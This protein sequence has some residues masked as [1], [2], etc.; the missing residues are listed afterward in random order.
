M[1][2]QASVS[3]PVLPGPKV[4]PKHLPS[5]PKIYKY[6]ECISNCSQKL[7]KSAPK[8]QYSPSSAPKNLFLLV[9][10]PQLQKSWE[11]LLQALI[12]RTNNYLDLDF[13]F[14]LYSC[15]ITNNT[16]KNDRR[17]GDRNYFRSFAKRIMYMY[18]YYQSN[19]LT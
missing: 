19:K 16:K 3:Q 14:T 7:N 17:S 18:Y 4:L 2:L 11:P 6:Q 9:S 10:A 1:I 13:Y 8:N 15:I 12:F 5:A